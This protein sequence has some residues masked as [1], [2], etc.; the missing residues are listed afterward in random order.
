[1]QLAHVTIE[2]PLA[3]LVRAGD[4]YEWMFPLTRGHGDDTTIRYM[5]GIH[6]RGVKQWESHSSY[7][8]LTLS[9]GTD[10]ETIRTRLDGNLGGRGAEDSFITSDPWGNKV[11][12]I[13]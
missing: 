3:H 1:M 2:I 8:H 13:R 7:P 4:W 11:R 6:L 10:F 12:C 5:E 9:L